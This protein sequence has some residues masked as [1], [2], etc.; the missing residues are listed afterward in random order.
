MPAV[1]QQETLA[2]TKEL[3]DGVDFDYKGRKLTC[4]ILDMRKCDIKESMLVDFLQL[5]YGNLGEADY[6]NLPK[7]E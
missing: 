4:S 1:L 6:F 5:I 3:E 7:F 2:N